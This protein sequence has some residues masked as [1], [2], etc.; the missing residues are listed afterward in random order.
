MDTEGTFFKKYRQ[1]Y[2]IIQG[3]SI[4]GPKEEITDWYEVS[5][6]YFM[7]NINNMGMELVSKSGYDPEGQ[8]R[9]QQSR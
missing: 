9:A 2:Q 5:K 4:S 3:D 6:D 7:A 8:N 1:Q